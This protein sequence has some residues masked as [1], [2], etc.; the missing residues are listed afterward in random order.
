MSFPGFF[1]IAAAANNGMMRYGADSFIRKNLR[2]EKLSGKSFYIYE[3]IS[4]YD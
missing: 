3:V 4:W 2:S 1:H